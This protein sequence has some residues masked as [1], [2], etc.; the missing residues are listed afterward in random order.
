MAVRKFGMF[1]QLCLLGFKTVD[2]DLLSNS[3][4]KYTD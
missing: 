1:S 4:E 3:A 2:R